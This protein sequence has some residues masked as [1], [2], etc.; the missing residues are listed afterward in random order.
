MMR[1]SLLPFVLLLAACGIR[2]PITT[3]VTLA[4]DEGGSRV[5]ITAITDFASSASG[6]A[7]SARVN[8]ARDN[9]LN[10][11]DEWSPRFRQVELESE[12]L[13]LERNGGVLSHVEQSVVIN[14]D[15]IQPVF[16]DTGIS[17]SMTRGE[18]WSQLDIYPGT[19]TRATRQQREHVER[20]LHVWSE[21]AARYFAA[22]HRVYGY[23]DAHPDR[24][25]PVFTILFSDKDGERSTIDDEQVLIDDLA[26]AMQHISDRLRADEKDAYT[27][28]EEFDLVYNPFPG[29]ITLRA[30]REIVSV[31]NFAK[32]SADTAVIRRS[33][34][35]DAMSALEGRWIAPDPMA[36]V[37]RAGDSDKTPM[38]SA[39][40]L[41]AM[42]RRST[43]MVTAEEI[44][45]AVVEKLKPATAYRVRWVER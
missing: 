27:L 25:Q 30:P 15:V 14:R 18:G 45:K 5:R 7:M 26:A 17:I 6:P 24:A 3:N 2:G 1:R 35:L 37:L 4:P 9:V 20:M 43:A 21:E 11:R 42:P 40:E 8:A 23:L 33:G 28:D 36:M 44:R 34:L 16:A 31:E 41:A 10:Y 19:S 29:E 38:P 39:A 12:R 22:V 32:T 13:V